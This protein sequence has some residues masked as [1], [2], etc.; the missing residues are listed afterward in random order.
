MKQLKISVRLVVLT[1]LMSLLLILLGGLGLMGLKQSND[2]L[3][4]V[5]EDRTVPTGQLGQLNQLMLHNRS[6]VM[7]MLMH[8]SAENTRRRTG[9]I[10]ENLAKYDVIWKAYMATTLTPEEATMVK[11]LDTAVTAYLNQGLRPAIQAVTESRHADGTKIYDDKIAVMAPDVQDRMN[12][13]VQLQM[14]VAK[15]EYQAAERRYESLRLWSLTAVLLGLAVA[16]VFSWTLIRG[17]TASLTQASDVANRVAE[18]DLT[19]AI[20]IDGKDEISEV[21][22]RLSGMQDGLRNVVSSV[23]QGSEG[24]ATA[25]AQIAQGTNDLSA[26]TEN[27]ASALEQTAASMEELSATVKQ[28]A[29]NARQANQLAQDASRIAVQGG[30]V[31]SEVVTTMRGINE[32]SN[33]I[34]DIISVIDGIAFQTNILAL[35]A[36]VEA[37]RAG[38]QGRGFAVVAGEVRTLAQRSAQAAKEIKNLITDSVSRVEQGS[39]L[40]DRAGSTMT[41]M[42]DSIR[43]VTTIMG[44]ISEASSE[45]SSGVSQIGEAVMQ[46]DQV[47]QQNAALVEEMSAAAT[48]LRQQAQDLLQVVSVFRVDGTGTVTSVSRAVETAQPAPRPMLRST[49]RPET[50]RARAASAALSTPR[51][52]AAA[53]PAPAAKMVGAP[54]RAKPAANPLAPAKSRTA[55]RPAPVAAASGDGDWESF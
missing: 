16:I 47:T 36:A 38:E 31:V 27:Q 12:A 40:A 8:E 44:E 21:L 51:T 26:R 23:R 20:V 34:A 35:N 5:Y 10:N 54:V 4:T 1:T 14:D 50:V 24:V 46:M 11:G 32:S 9:Q 28:N 22:H 19:R 18:G 33:K 49:P 29:D 48:N 2:G 52:G 37:A 39:A 13:L 42:V 15:A 6:L 45:Q 3:R 55:G 30:E 41:Q 7:D 53:K 25:S 17:I 43:Q